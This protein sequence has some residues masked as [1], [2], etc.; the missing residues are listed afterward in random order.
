MG[1]FVAALNRV[2]FAK[3]FPLRIQFPRPVGQGPSDAGPGCPATW[4]LDQDPERAEKLK[5][6]LQEWGTL[7]CGAHWEF[8]PADHAAATA[9]VEHLVALKVAHTLDYLNFST[10]PGTLHVRG[11]VRDAGPADKLKAHFNA[12]LRFGLLSEVTVLGLGEDTG[13]I[14][15]FDN[16]LDAEHILRLPRPK[17]FGDAAQVSRYVLKR[18]KTHDEAVLYDTVV[19]ESVE[20]FGRTLLAELGVFLEKL[21]LFAPVEAVFFPVRA[22]ELDLFS[23]GG[24]GFVLFGGSNVNTNVL[25]ALYYLTDLTREELF[26]FTEADIYDIMDDLDKPHQPREGLKMSIAHGKHNRHIYDLLDM[27]YVCWGPAGLEV[28]PTSITESPLKLRFLKLANYQETN[29]YV[30]GLPMAFNNDDELWVSFWNQFGVGGVKLAKIIKPQYYSRK[31]DDALGKIGFVFYR[32]FK[33]AIRAILCTNNRVLHDS[34]F[35]NVTVQT[36]FAIQKQGTTGPRKHHNSV[37]GGHYPLEP[38]RKRYSL[39]E[40]RSFPQDP[41]MYYPYY[42]PV[43]EEDEVPVGYYYPFAHPMV[44]AA[45]FLGYTMQFLGDKK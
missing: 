3:P 12:A 4:H 14:L 35:P 16:F 20:F 9:A 21:A 2:L 1:D 13:A 44:L 22:T 43:S 25:R 7:Q 42:L 27:P 11:I 41:F 33:M 26:R 5:L 6:A 37:P 36:L 18:D 8:C 30:N 28:C 10:H 23:L 29:V 15:R 31:P 40:A 24:P 19:V 32:E 39:P 38:F 34:K 45:P 17:A